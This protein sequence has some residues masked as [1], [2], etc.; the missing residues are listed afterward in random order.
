MYEV[1]KH[2]TPSEKREWNMKR[3]HKQEGD[4]EYE[5]HKESYYSPGSYY[6]YLI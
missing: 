6:L 3:N 1:Y 4:K 2:T 5:H